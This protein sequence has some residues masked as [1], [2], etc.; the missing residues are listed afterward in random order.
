[1]GEESWA[2]EQHINVHIVSRQQYQHLVSATE[3]GSQR[4]TYKSFMMW[5]C[6]M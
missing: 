6:Q 1:M 2:T 3:S 5:Q 4:N